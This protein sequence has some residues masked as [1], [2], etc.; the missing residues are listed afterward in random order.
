MESIKVFND[1]QMFNSYIGFI[2]LSFN[3]YLLHGAE[4]LLVHTGSKDQTVEILPKIK[5]ILGGKPLKYIF[6]SHFESDECGGLS[7]LMEHYPDAK[8]VCSQVTARQLMGFGIANDIITKAP[9]DVLETG[10]FRLRFV[11]YPS[12][13]HLWEGL[14]AFEEERGLLFSSD[15]FIRFGKMNNPIVESDL[16]QEIQRISSQQIPDSDALKA[17]QHDLKNL[18]IKY[19][20]PGHGPCL[21][22]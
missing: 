18:D 3:Q 8:P 13:M 4:P 1:L 16:D 22:V 15:L 10:E 19:I 7:Y 14:M 5:D 12:E 20:I 11:R 9:G 21:K 2:D 6:I 17:V